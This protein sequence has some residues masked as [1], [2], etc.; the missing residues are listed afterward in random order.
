M[1]LCVYLS[2]CS[3]V[4]LSTCL[5]SEFRHRKGHRVLPFSSSSAGSNKIF[6]IWLT[7]LYKVVCLPVCPFVC[8]STC[9][10]LCLTYLKFP[11]SEGSW[12]FCHSRPQAQVWTSASSSICF[13]VWVKQKQP[14]HLSICLP[15]HVS[16]CLTIFL[17]AILFIIAILV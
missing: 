3:F 1:C 6:F 11:A 17:S 14:F 13:Y 8:L 2:V 5:I 7:V 16:I 15:V 9:P 12:E 4:H 10:S